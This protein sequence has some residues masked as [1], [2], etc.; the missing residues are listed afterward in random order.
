MSRPSLW[1]ELKR[2]HVYRV[3]VAYGV[4]SW[5][6]VEIT[7]QVFPVFG[8]PDW[9]VRLLIVLLLTGFPLVLVLAWALEITPAGIRRTEPL[10]SAAVRAA[11]DAEK[12]RRQLNFLIIVILLLTLSVL[13]VR[14]FVLPALRETT[15]PSAD[16]HANETAPHAIVGS[17]A[18]LPFENLSTDSDN[19]YF[20]D[21]IRDEILS[22]L[23]RIGQIKVLSPVSTNQYSGAPENAGEIGRQLGVTSILS[24]RVR[25]SG[26]RV[27][28]S[29][30][31]TETASDD[32]VWAETYDRNLGD[33]FAVQSEVA[34]R[35]AEALHAT[36]SSAEQ[37]AI[38][39]VPTRNRDAYASYLKARALM[40]RSV[41]ERDNI[42]AIIDALEQAV[43]LDDGFALA[44]AALAEQHVWMYWEGFD[45]T[46]ARLEQAS[47][48]LRRARQLT[49]SQPE[50]QLAQ[51]IFDYYGKRNFQAALEK[52][53]KA[54]T[55]IPNNAWAW[56]ASALVERRLGDWP[57]AL[58]DFDRA[59]ELNP[60][61]LSLI[62]NHAITQ[63]ATRDFD[64]ALATAE[65][66]LALK[67]DNA[68][69]M[70]LR[71]FCL[72]NLG[73]SNEADHV[74]EGLPEDSLS[75]AVARAHRAFYQRR[76]ETASQ[77]FSSAI[78]LAGERHMAASFSGYVPAV[79]DLR[80]QQALSDDRSGRRQAALA[81]FG[82]VATLARAGL[83]RQPGSANVRAAL[84]AVLAMALAGQGQADE[85][86]AEARRAVAMVPA[87]A[88]A[89]E[90][91]VWLEYLA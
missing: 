75:G 21:G 74:I 45:P 51:G 11:E 50:V 26:S 69:L 89:A 64:G 60:N 54:R 22:G 14:Q 41:F 20:A 16:I 81:S 4:G 8:I 17:V 44:W 34:Q 72:Q 78:D 84:H 52:L 59:R 79:L 35:I 63:S 90:G 55:G 91:P 42:E 25:K 13:V 27:R 77:A 32:T 67:A 65:L 39:R 66:G 76:F 23:S 18:V 86:L 9:T 38:E 47:A 5:L 70:A 10:G 57:A 61:D 29:V 12:V 68:T 71:I 83:A 19:A 62:A 85:A 73:R 15:A 46:D 49:P 88:D 80:L 1:H 87:S 82:Q 53:K 31:L 48:A 6:I 43:S 28:I 30:Q 2:R 40:A 56:H 3:A 36:L 37:R 24:G 58:K 33:I 7:S